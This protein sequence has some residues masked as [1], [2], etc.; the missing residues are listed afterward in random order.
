MNPL[1]RKWLLTELEQHI[2]YN[3]V[4]L[5]K[6]SMNLLK[7]KFPPTHPNEFYHHMTID[8]A[9]KKYPLDIGQKV[10]LNVI[11]YGED[12]F[13]QAVVVTGFHSTNKIPHITLSTAEGVKPVYSNKMLKRGFKEIEPFKITGTVSSFTKNGW[14]DG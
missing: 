14:V 4:R 12:E 2:I 3:A 8:F 7:K 11:G 10:S 6:D 1:N 9:V 13:A 5:D